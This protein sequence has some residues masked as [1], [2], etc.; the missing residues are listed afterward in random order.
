[1]ARVIISFLGTGGYHDRDNKSRGSYRKTKYS[2]GDTIYKCEFVADALLRHYSAESIVYVGT[3]KSMWE[4]VYDTFVPNAS[5]DYWQL[6]AEVVDEA[7]PQ[8]SIEKQQIISEIFKGTI[9]TPVILKYGLNDEEN[10]YNI[11]RLFEI[12][13]LFE[14]GDKLYL[15]ISHGFRSLPIVLTSVLNFIINNSNKK[16]ILE[17]I[18]YGMFEVSHEMNHVSP[19]INLDIIMQLNKTL[20]AAHE[21][22][23]YGNGY[24]FA[25]LLEMTNKSI[26]SIIKSFSDSK[27]LN[28]IYDLKNKIQ[29]LNGLNYENLNSIQRVTIIPVIKDFTSRFEKAKHDSHFQYEVSKWMFDNKQYGSASIALI[30][31]LITKVCEMERWSTD[32]L[33]NRDNAKTLIVLSGKSEKNLKKELKNKHQAELFKSARA[34]NAYHQIWGET[35]KIRKSVSHSINTQLSVNKMVSDLNKYIDQAKELIYV[36]N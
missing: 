29:Q 1:M 3:L 14:N 13:K 2:I 32:N 25:D 26:S 28:H 9:I 7:N 15:D 23:E 8:T 18:S 16:L 24:I 27:S 31:S 12:E 6:L 21:F 30:E 35:N 4:V 33:K 5:A 10:E 20:N 22:K 19:I 36:P 17:H 34:Y 11:T